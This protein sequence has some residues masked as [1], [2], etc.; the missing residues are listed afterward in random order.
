MVCVFF[1]ISLPFLIGLLLELLSPRNYCAQ[2]PLH[3]ECNNVQMLIL[4]SELLQV[5]YFSY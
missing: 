1:S 4:N 5:K 2:F 3:L